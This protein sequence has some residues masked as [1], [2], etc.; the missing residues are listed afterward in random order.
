MKRLIS[1]SAPIRPGEHPLNDFPKADD[2][3]WATFLEQCRT[4][5][6]MDVDGNALHPCKL[7]QGV[8]ATSFLMEVEWDDGAPTEAP[9]ALSRDIPQ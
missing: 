6:V 2:P 8:N 1:A 5:G 9:A 3:R 4:Q 7:R